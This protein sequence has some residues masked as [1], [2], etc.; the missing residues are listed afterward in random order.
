MWIRTSRILVLDKK[1]SLSLDHTSVQ[2]LRDANS[3]KEADD[4][5][6]RS[7]LASKNVN[8]R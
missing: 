7:P 8:L 1:A 3:Q 4:Y 5:W 2:A 6:S